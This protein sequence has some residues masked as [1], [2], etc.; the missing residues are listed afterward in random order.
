MLNNLKSLKDDMNA[1]GWTICS[2][3]FRHKAINYIVLV[4]RFVGEESG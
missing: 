2:F 4:K 3:T 1:K